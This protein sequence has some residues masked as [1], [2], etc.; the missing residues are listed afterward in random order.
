M[1]STITLLA[2]AIA[3]QATPIANPVGNS[4]YSVP[5]LHNPSYVRNGTAALLK[6]YAKHRLTPTRELPS[7]FLD[8]L[9]KRQDGS[10]TAE[11]SNGVQYLIPVT[12]GGE[13]LA[14]DLDTGS[15]DL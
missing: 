4:H 12:I 13:N 8:A 6:A 7:A 9:Q 14:L 2:L 15:A 10:V 3:A 5:A 11:P 1:L